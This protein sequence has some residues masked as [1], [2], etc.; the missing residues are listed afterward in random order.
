MPL[1]K[2]RRKWD[3]PTEK[4]STETTAKQ[5]FIA[6][7]NPPRTSFK[8][9]QKPIKSEDPFDGNTGY[10]N[11]YVAHPVQPRKPKQRKIHVP[12]PE[13][14]D[15]TST[16]KNDFRGD[17]VP[18]RESYKRDTEPF[19]SNADFES[20]TTA[21]TDYKSHPVERR[22]ARK[23]EEY[24]KPEGKIDLDTVNRSNYKEHP[25]QKQIVKKPSS[26]KALRGEGEVEKDT[27]YIKDYP[28][29]DAKRPEKL[30]QNSQYL[31]P[32]GKM[33]GITT[34][35]Q[36]YPP[37]KGEVRKGFKPKESELKS[38]DPLDTHTGYKNTYVEHPLQPKQG[39][40]REEYKP[41][42]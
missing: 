40:Q 20:T 33:D 38:T 42:A 30:T 14:F 3:P 29:W 41:P 35:K 6:K 23:P 2:P 37:L 13:K 24:T 27:N 28:A 21:G 34:S 16:A 19:K 39:R 10:K 11:V 5:D 18:K 12:P 7:G 36:D 9:S 32:D 22:I 26:S 4:F 31:P 15:A 1:K 17:V 8:P 25:I